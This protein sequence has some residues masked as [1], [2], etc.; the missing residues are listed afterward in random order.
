[1]PVLDLLHRTAVRK[2]VF[3]SSRRWLAVAIG[4]WSFRQIIKL[5]ARRETVVLREELQP[6]ESLLVTHTSATVD[7]L[8]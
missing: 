8:R 1:M 5:A 6:G 2:G 7:T 3:G 4:T